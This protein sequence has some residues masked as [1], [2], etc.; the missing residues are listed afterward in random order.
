MDRISGIDPTP[1][2]FGENLFRSITLNQKKTPANTGFLLAGSWIR[3]FHRSLLDYSQRSRF[4]SSSLARC[5]WSDLHWLRI[6]SRTAALVIF[7][8]AF[9]VHPSRSSLGTAFENLL[10][11]GRGCECTTSDRLEFRWSHLEW[12][13]FGGTICRFDRFLWVEPFYGQQQSSAGGLVFFQN[14]EEFLQ[15]ADPI[16]SHF[17]VSLSC[18]GRIWI[19]QKS[20]SLKIII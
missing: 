4:W 5:I 2:G 9:A 14:T 3:L 12:L 18:C 8:W 1:F 19:S 13:P 11:C 10:V 16:E 7:G 6:R 20:N 15:D 17:H